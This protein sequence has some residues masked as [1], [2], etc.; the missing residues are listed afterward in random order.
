MELL[1]I[2][3]TK[4]Q[5][6]IFGSNRLRENLGASYLVAAATEDWVVDA[7]E[8]DGKK[9]PRLSHNMK[10][11]GKK[12]VYVD[13]RIERDK[14]DAE[15]VYMGGGNAV[16]LFTSPKKR[17]LFVAKYSRHVLAHAPNLQIVIAHRPID[18]SKNNL[19]T[20]MKLAFQETVKEAKRQRVPSNPLPVPSAT[21]LP[22][23]SSKVQWASSPSSLES[24]ATLM[25]TVAVAWPPC[26]SSTV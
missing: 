21:A 13:R 2:D 5:P 14:L 10:K 19:R 3:T 11:R 17:K 23:P 4:I 8:R 18:W 20:E 12:W 16:L 9:R 1:V 26:P 7:L 22:S 6:Y 15:I 24:A 25:V